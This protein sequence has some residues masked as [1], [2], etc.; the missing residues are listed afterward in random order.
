MCST[1]RRVYHAPWPVPQHCCCSCNTPPA[2]RMSGCSDIGDILAPARHG[3]L[4]VRTHG[5]LILRMDGQHRWARRNSAPSVAASSTSML[6][7]LQPRKGLQPTDRARVGAQHLI[8][9]IVAHAH[10]E[11]VVRQGMLAA[12]AYFS[13]SSSCVSVL[14][15]RV[16]H[17]H[18]AGDAAGRRRRGRRCDIVLVGKTGLPEMHLVIDHAGQQEQAF[19][20]ELLRTTRA[21][22]AASLHAF[23][24]ATA[25]Q[26]VGLEVRSL[27]SPRWRCGSAGRSSTW[28]RTRI[29]NTPMMASLK[30]FE[31]ILLLPFKRSTKVMGT[32]AIRKPAELAAVLH[33]DLER[34]THELRSRPAPIAPAHACGS[35]RN[36]PWYRERRATGWY[37]HRAKR[38]SSASRGPRTNPAPV[39]PS[40]NA[41]QR[42][43]PRHPR[44]KRRTT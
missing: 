13:A 25:H 38:N 2:L 24:A 10:V 29:F 41:N 22:D 15:H 40:R 43:Y 12:S 16:R 27:R 36:R 28:M 20:I 42:S 37:A 14:R 17:L 39:R 6:P 33:F 23:N 11:G 8:Q 31:F 3:G 9:V 34:V 1:C 44:H 26:H 32:S 30:M 4:L 5:R 7:V 35:K 21:A 18:E 19:G